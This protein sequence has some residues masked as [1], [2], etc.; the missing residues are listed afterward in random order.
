VR[1]DDGYVSAAPG[2]AVRVPL[3]SDRSR[4][5]VG[6]GRGVG[7]WAAAGLEVKLG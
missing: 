6:G 5:A 7:C 2:D 3:V 1:D 4:A